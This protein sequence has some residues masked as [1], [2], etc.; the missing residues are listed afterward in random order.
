MSDLLKWLRVGRK[1]ERRREGRRRQEIKSCF[2]CGAGGVI[3]RICAQKV[4][5]KVMEQFSSGAEC[6]GFG[7]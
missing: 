2:R 7:S 5:Q 6:Q 1:E 4:A 3:T